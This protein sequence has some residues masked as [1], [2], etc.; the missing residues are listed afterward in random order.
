M[1]KIKDNIFHACFGNGLTFWRAGTEINIAH[2]D[3]HRVIKFYSGNHTTEEEKDYIKEVVR[4]Y[5][6]GIS[7]T[8]PE[9][10]VFSTAVGTVTIYTP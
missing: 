7:H 6:G 2:A 1:T 10:K 9:Y 5:D 8:Q 4:N 3:A